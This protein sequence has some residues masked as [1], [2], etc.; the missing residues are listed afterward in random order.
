MRNLLPPSSGEKKF[1]RNDSSYTELHVV[2]I[3]KTEIS[4]G[5]VKGKVVSEVK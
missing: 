2:M 4:S 5:R 1:L 3:Q